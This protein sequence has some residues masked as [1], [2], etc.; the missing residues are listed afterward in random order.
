MPVVGFRLAVTAHDHFAGEVGSGP[1]EEEDGEAAG[2]CAHKVDGA[3]GGMGVVAEED[4]KE[5]AHH[6]EEGGAGRV[7][8]LEFIAARDKFAAVPEAAGGFHGHHE[9]GAG[10][11]ADDPAG[12]KIVTAEGAGRIIH[13]IELF[14]LKLKENAG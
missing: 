13:I 6:D 10:D 14:H 11:Q 9:Y 5:A 3:G 2:D 4:D 1:E 12:D 7:G 8:N